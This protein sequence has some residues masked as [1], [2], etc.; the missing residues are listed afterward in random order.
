MIEPDTARLPKTL[1]SA[2]N[3]GKTI[4]KRFRFLI[5]DFVLSLTVVSYSFQ[6]QFSVKTLIQTDFDPL[7]GFDG[8]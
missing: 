1:I 6:I 2:I 3:I 8:R 7:Y 4:Y 5:V